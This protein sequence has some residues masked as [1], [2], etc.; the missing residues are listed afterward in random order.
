MLKLKNL[1]K[2]LGEFSLHNINLD[3]EPGDYFILLG[4]SG[5]GKTILLELIAGLLQ[6]DLGEIWLQEEIITHTKIQ[7]RKV[8]IVFQDYALFPNMNVRENI[9]YGLKR[10]KLS[11]A[12]CNQRIE[13]YAHV[14]EINHLLHRN[15]DH[16]S[17]GELQRVAIARTLV[18]KPSCLLLDEPLSSLDVQLRGGLRNM[19]RQIN[20]SGVT[21]LHVTHDYQEA[22]ALSNKVAVINQG[23]II[24][25][26]STKDVFRNPAN[27]F[28]ANFTGVKNF[29]LAEFKGNTALLKN[30]IQLHIVNPDRLTEGKV[31]IQSKYIVVSP[32]ELNSSSTNNFRGALRQVI[33]HQSNYE[34]VVD[35]GV[36]LSVL[37]SE[38]S[39]QKYAFAPGTELWVSFKANAIQLL[40]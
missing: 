35:I 26:G 15:I 17:G 21:I 39:L 25:C 20:K 7:L 22:I 32:E 37:I 33:P 40:D 12:E 5:A 23:R 2:Q 30:N 38:E 9:E 34:L 11:P 16:L 13:E 27:E 1:T 19:L 36:E 10:D 14:T 6:P 29:F 24:Q 8:G 28:V 18:K 3:I 4:R 31:I